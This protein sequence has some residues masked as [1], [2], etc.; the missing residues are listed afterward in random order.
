MPRKRK[1]EDIYGEMANTVDHEQCSDIMRT[2][3]QIQRPLFIKGPPGIGKSD[4]VRQV[5]KDEANRKGLR[6]VEYKDEPS[7]LND[8][9]CFVLIDLRLAQL[10]P[11]DLR[12]IPWVYAVIKLPSG[13]E[14]EIFTGEKATVVEER[15]PHTGK[16]EP[17]M[18]PDGDIKTEISKDQLM[19]IPVSV[20]SQYPDA[21][22]VQ[23]VTKW[24]PPSDLPIQGRGVIFLDEMNIAAELNM[25][26]AYQL[27]L[28]RCLGEYKV[29][30]GFS[31][32]AAGNRMEDMASITPM[33]SP[34]KNR[35][36]WCELRAP[37]ADEWTEWASINGIH[38]LVIGYLQWKPNALN[39]Y[40]PNAKSDAQPSP[41]SWEFSSDILNKIGT[42]DMEIVRLMLATSVGLEVANEVYAF[43]KMREQLP[44][45]AE[46]INDPRN[47]RV[48]FD[49]TGIVWTLLSALSERYR[50]SL[51]SK[52]ENKVLDACL[53]FCHRIVS[54]EVRRPE[55]AVV[56][57]S[58]L[59]AVD[60]QL[61]MKV[62]NNK[63]FMDISTELVV[64]VGSGFSK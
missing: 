24:S 23:L 55:F 45:I 52:S 31:I 44:P 5:A 59:K 8:P 54:P 61:K 1:E 57:F 12:G 41:R 30:D 13:E 20:L 4:L 21:E 25:K 19:Q 50:A 27:I 47:A 62:E 10:D 2:C 22:I 36:L 14:R 7:A 15:D 60:P 49:D 34:L 63:L 53:Q 32:I 29:P 39:L 11:S 3:I 40:D 56:F 28:R 42:D 51:G 37:M 33:P 38:P 43:I 46:F 48:N 58:M 35:F 26:A 9:T 16:T 64:F 6:Y 17:S 18:T